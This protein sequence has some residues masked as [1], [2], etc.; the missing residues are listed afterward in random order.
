MPKTNYGNDRGPETEV[1]EEP[2][3]LIE[4]AFPGS[5]AAEE[6]RPVTSVQSMP[7]GFSVLRNVKA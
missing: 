6:A 2:L 4:S 7:L 5:F 1:F 3:D